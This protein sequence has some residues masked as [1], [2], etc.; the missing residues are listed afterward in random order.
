MAPTVLLLLFVVVGPTLGT[1]G[2]SF[3]KWDGLRPAIFVGFD[4]FAQ[5]FTDPVFY[6]AL[7]NNMKWLLYFCTIPIVVGLFNAFMISRSGRLQI[8]YRTI[9]FL[10]YI[11]STVVTA[12]IWKW[13]YDPFFGLNPSLGAIGV[14]GLPN[15]LGDPGIALY[16]V[17][18][19]DSWRYTGFLMVLFLTALTQTDRQLEEAALMDG[20]GRWRIFKSVILPQLRPTITLILMLTMIWSFAAFDYV[21]VMTN[22][23]PGRATELLATYMYSATI[24]G[25]AAGYA[26]T[27]SF[28]M[29]FFSGIVMALYGLLK[30]RGW[31]V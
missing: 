23:G 9:Y 27:I 6:Q 14:K 16:S 24:K 7:I 13:I 20:A 22:G 2:L 25:Q 8:V 28:T 1:L 3:F 18:L 4:N 19:T 10:P 29:L 30:K 21:Y 12:M 31:E 17:A 26:S 5:L 11:C 15:W